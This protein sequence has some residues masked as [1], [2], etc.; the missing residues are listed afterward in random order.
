[1]KISKKELET[2]IKEELAIF[3]KNKQALL[4]ESLEKVTFK[5]GDRFLGTFET[6]LQEISEPLTSPLSDAKFSVLKESSSTS[7]ED[8][9]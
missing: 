5:E 2:I 6:F 7:E 9:D 8:N 1:M 3:Q 4:N